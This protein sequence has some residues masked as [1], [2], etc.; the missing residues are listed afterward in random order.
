MT[1]R[2]R[3]YLT[4]KRWFRGFASN[5]F[6]CQSFKFPKQRLFSLD[7]MPKGFA[8]AMPNFCYDREGNIIP[9]ANGDK[10]STTITW[11]PSEED[12]LCWHCNGTG[13]GQSPDS[14]CSYCNGRGVERIKKDDI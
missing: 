14:I 8:L 11:H 2:E 5:G 7:E 4:N 12:K 10:P 6:H 1:K 9:P 13:E 3:K